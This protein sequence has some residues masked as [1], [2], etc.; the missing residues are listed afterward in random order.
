VI[1]LEMIERYWL[2]LTAPTSDWEPIE[3]V[4]LEA[5][6]TP[7][8]HPLVTIDRQ[9]LRHLLIP[10]PETLK[11]L[12]DSR[13][14]GIH[15]GTSSW[16]DQDVNRRFVDLVCRKPHLNALF[17]KIIFEVFTLLPECPERPDEACARTL[18]RWRELFERE[19]ISILNRETL[20]GLFGELIVLKRLAQENLNAVG[21]WVGPSGA[22]HDFVSG[23]QAIEVKTTA[24][25]NRKQIAVH[26]IDQLEAPQDT[27]LYLVFIEV[28]ETVG[29]NGISVLELTRELETLGC[30][31][32][33]V[34]SKL[35]DA[36]ISPDAIKHT[37]QIKFHLI[38]SQLYK[39][40]AD[41]PRIIRESLKSNDLP[42]GVS[43]VQYSVDLSAMPPYPLDDAATEDFFRNFAWSNNGA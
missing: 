25:R 22:R 40:D 42:R 18:S 33:E 8:G 9:E 30:S 11:T 7:Y 21:K 6:H 27:S 39:I 12:E 2:D 1:P 10:I 43:G 37:E 32:V 35:A 3:V 28:E 34:W 19:I 16:I 13:S 38:S 41:F 17:N 24:Q 5:I 36:A 29:S 15:L 20:V 14:Q 31:S 23:R 26:G 4:E